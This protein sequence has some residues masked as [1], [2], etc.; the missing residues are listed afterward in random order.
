MALSTG[1]MTDNDRAGKAIRP[2][3]PELVDIV[4]RDW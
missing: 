2:E 4:H 3:V 1:V